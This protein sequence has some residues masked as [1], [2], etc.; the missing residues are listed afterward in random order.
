MDAIITVDERQHVVMFNAAAEQI[1]RCP[2]NAAIGGPLDRF[3]PERFRAAHRGHVERFAATG[4]TVRRMGSDMLLHGLRAGGE[5]FPIEASISQATVDGRKLFT[6]VLRDITER[7]RVETEVRKERDL[8][9]KYL[10]VAD[11]ILVA[12]DSKGNV[13]LINRKGCEV[14]GYPEEEIVGQCWIDRFLPEG[15]RRDVQT[16]FRQIM[17]GESQLAEFHENPVLTRGGAERMIAWHNR[18]LRDESGTIV[19][20]LSSGEDITE[21]K[22]AEAALER[23][24]GELRE[25]YRQMHEVREGERMRIARELHDELAQWLTALKMDVSWVAGRLSADDERGREKVE[26]M[27]QL[28]NS[29]VTSVRRI[30]H[31]LR[32]SMLDDLGLVPAIEHL[33]H[34]FSERTGLVVELDTQA[35]TV[36]FREPLSTAVYRMVQEGLTNVARHARA[37]EVRVAL[38]VEG[39]D[40]VVSVRDN[41]IGI[42][43]AQLGSGKS[44]GLLGIK[45]RARTL[46]GAADIY[47]VREGG[48]TV[49]IKVPVARYLGTGERA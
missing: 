4:A 28:V 16:V 22:R 31:D 44:F 48:T 17:A 15:H 5:E 1:F 11:V 41:G 40:L 36:E 25:L 33:L 45:E 42:S 39:G 12:L 8:A 3:I 49:E 13:T 21:R 26:R 18:A 27:K 2:A 37:T 35:A 19:G 7:K 24:Y 23:S 43:E 9:Q 34:A 32:P 30:A 29:A 10:D 20:T 47:S 38:R 14:L 46:G 6:V